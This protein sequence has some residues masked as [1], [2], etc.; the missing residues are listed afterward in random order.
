MRRPLLRLVQ[1]EKRRESRSIA[2]TA[3]LIIATAIT[4][5]MILLSGCGHSPTYIETY[6]G[7]D[8]WSEFDCALGIERLNE[9]EI[10]IDRVLD[11]LG[12]SNAPDANLSFFG[13]VLQWTACPS[14]INH[15]IMGCYR[16]RERKMFVAC[17]H[18]G[19][20]IVGMDTR[21]VVAHELIRH[22]IFVRD[23][24]VPFDQSD[25]LFNEVLLD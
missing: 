8:I 6:R 15:S 20:A 3:I 23:G 10:G 5:C 17:M 1:T 16:A 18:N 4:L 14:E 21:I 12:V 11:Y 24:I 25:P 13:P 19:Q 22:W 9:S 2:M 7:I